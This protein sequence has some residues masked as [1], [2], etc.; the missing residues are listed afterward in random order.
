M[1]VAVAACQLRAEGFLSCLCLCHAAPGSL[2]PLAIY[3]DNPGIASTA[4]RPAQQ[5][6]Q[7][8]LILFYCALPFNDTLVHPV[9]AVTV[10][11][12]RVTISE[13]TSVMVI[14]MER[15]HC[16]SLLFSFGGWLLG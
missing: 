3:T 16:T 4:R 10:A 7:R 1:V 15:T 2:Y 5:M 14:M 6:N 9:T 8:C 12:V 11:A 13:L